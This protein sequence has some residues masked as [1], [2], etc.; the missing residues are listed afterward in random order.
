MSERGGM[1][2]RDFLSCMAWTGGGLLWSLVGGVPHSRAF[3]PG[4]AEARRTTSPPRWTGSPTRS[5]IGREQQ[6]VAGSCLQ[7]VS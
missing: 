7:V 2:R 6:D 3:G 1:E 5:R 4:A